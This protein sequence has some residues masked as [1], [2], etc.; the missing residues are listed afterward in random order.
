VL[1]FSK[2][3]DE[4]QTF[5]MNCAGQGLTGTSS[6]IDLFWRDLPVNIGSFF[7]SRFGMAQIMDKPPHCFCAKTW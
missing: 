5:E 4:W 7:E 1:V 3:A 2:S 6:T